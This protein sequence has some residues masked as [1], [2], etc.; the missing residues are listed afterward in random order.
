ERPGFG[1]LAESVSG[2]AHM[3]GPA[4]GPP[5]LP[6]VA[7]ADEVTA[8]LGAYAVMVALYRRDA[9][10]RGERGRGQVI[11]L[12]LFESLFGI[13]GP[14]PAVHATLGIVPGRLGNA[15]PYAAPRGAYPTKDGRWVGVS[16]TSQTVAA[17]IFSAIGRPELIED[18]RFA[19]NEARVRHREDLDR[20]IE[21][22]TK[23]RSL[24]EVLDVFERAHAA[25]API[26]DIGQILQDPQYEARGTMVTVRDGELGEVTLADVQPRLSETPGRIRHAGLPKGSSNAEVN[27]E[28]GLSGT[29]MATLRDEGVL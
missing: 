20:I 7:L 25:A 4:D 1:T 17:R 22:W 19:T 28:L 9:G 6:P 12:S 27:A 15:I 5:I 18:P 2:F 3:N 8:L 14:I 13:L 16:G 29:E 23:E 10:P 26:Y 11:D 21:A 24:Q